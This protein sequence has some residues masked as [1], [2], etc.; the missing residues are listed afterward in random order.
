[1]K[2]AALLRGIGP[3]NPNMSHESFRKFFESL[4]FQKVVPVIS[5]GNIIFE[6]EENDIKVLENKIE[7]SLPKK[8]GF[9]STTIVRSQT[10]LQKLLAQDPFAGFE[11][12]HSSTLN[13]TF[14]KNPTKTDLEFP[15][16]I[17]NKNY[18]IVGIFENA[19]FSVIDLNSERT[20]DLMTWLE[21]KFSKEI[22]TR[23]WKTV[24]RILSKMNQK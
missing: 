2:Y 19:V 12:S 7:E 6:T 8:L 11:D 9:S 1:M 21:K 3:G 17:E 23:T 14:L 16:Q 22:T 13:V 15:Y 18:K 20:P 5:S 24:N 4:G 10:E